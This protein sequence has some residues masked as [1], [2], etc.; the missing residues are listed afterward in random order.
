MVISSRVLKRKCDK[1]LLHLVFLS[2]YVT[3]LAMKD[4]SSGRQGKEWCESPPASPV[5][6]SFLLPT[7]YRYCSHSGISP[8]LVEIFHLLYPD[9]WSIIILSLKYNKIKWPLELLYFLEKISY[10]ITKVKLSRVYLW[11]FQVPK[12]YVLH[13]QMIQ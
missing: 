1:T 8:F 5:S 11:K 13:S 6:N 12:H 2:T 3:D 10:S 4:S 9:P 7:N